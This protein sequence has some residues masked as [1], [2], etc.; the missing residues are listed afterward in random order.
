MKAASMATLLF[1]QNRPVEESLFP[2]A[3]KSRWRGR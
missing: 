1:D 2:V 3:M